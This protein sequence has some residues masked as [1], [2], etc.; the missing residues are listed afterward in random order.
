MVHRKFAFIED[1]DIVKN[2]LGI[3]ACVM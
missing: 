1:E 3:Y 2:S